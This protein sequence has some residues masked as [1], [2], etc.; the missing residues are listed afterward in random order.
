MT[1]TVPIH[2]SVHKGGQIDRRLEDRKD[3][4]ITPPSRFAFQRSRAAECY[5][6]SS[7]LASARASDS[8][9][10]RQSALSSSRIET[11]AAQAIA[12]QRS[13]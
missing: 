4:T 10:S 2:R 1:R 12:W 6:V 13:T 11:P 3:T 8:R 9:E 5:A 7:L